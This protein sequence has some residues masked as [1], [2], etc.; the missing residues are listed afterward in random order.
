VTALRLEVWPTASE[1]VARAACFVAARLAADPGLVLGLATGTTMMPLYRRLVA[2]QAA[3]DISFARVTIFCL[4]EY[5]G[6]SF[7]HPA[8]FRRYLH[9]HLLDKVDLP[10]D[11]ALLLDGAAADPAVECANY[12]RKIAAV[13]GIGLQLLG[14]G[15]NG[16]IGFNEP[17]SSFDSRTR[18]VALSPETRADNASAFDPEPAPEQALT[19]GI[20][21]ILDAREL[22]LVAT[23]GAKSA[24][25]AAAIDGPVSTEWP[26]SALQLHP[27]ATI[28][29][30][31]AAARGLLAV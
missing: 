11:R 1:A 20:G 6:L 29:C 22:L 24:A 7:E 25:L 16:H 23:G 15:A 18:L 2:R 17:G 31:A 10:I 28:V 9:C 26:A 30:D 5:A 3:G 12:E 21:T 8:S 14:I 13:G 27:R 19:M 4:D